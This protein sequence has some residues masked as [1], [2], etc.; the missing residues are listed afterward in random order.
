MGVSTCDPLRR[1]Q[2]TLYELPNFGKLG[3]EL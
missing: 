2:S 1:G 3:I